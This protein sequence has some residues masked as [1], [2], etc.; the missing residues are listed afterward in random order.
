MD[1]KT[2]VK[3][4]YTSTFDDDMGYAIE[5]SLTFGNL[6]AAMLNGE[7]FYGVLGAMDSVVRERVFEGIVKCGLAKDYNMVYNVWLDTTD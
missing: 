3:E 2:N 7:E 6:W 1:Y 4:W 5:D